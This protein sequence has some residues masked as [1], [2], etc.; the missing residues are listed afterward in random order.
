[1]EKKLKGTVSMKESEMYNIIQEAT[2]ITFQ[3]SVRHG[4]AEYHT[5]QGMLLNSDLHH[6][7]CVWPL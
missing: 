6:C 1:M 7:K 3:E 2:T 5:P 4:S